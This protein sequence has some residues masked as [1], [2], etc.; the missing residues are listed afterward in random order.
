MAIILFFQQTL[1]VKFCKQSNMFF[2]L[3][4]VKDNVSLSQCGKIIN[5]LH[6]IRLC[7][8]YG[9]GNTTFPIENSEQPTIFCIIFTCDISLT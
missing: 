4:Y 2:F 7:A 1:L 8:Y 9:G 6:I 5:F 3:F